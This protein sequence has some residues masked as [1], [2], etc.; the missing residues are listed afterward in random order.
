[1][2]Q[3]NL[4]PT[5]QESPDDAPAESPLPSASGPPVSE[6]GE[7]T[8]SRAKDGLM[9][10]A[11]SGSVGAAG[12]FLTGIF[13]MPCV[14]ATRSARLE[15]QS[16]QQE[17]SQQIAQIDAELSDDLAERDDSSHDE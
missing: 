1:M 6:F 11:F 16:R 8:F 4:E 10:A 7:R 5:S 3:D 13:L 9:V 17:A 12:I 15:W 2:S 14:G